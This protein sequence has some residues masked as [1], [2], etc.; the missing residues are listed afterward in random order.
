MFKKLLL[1]LMPLLGVFLVL[2]LLLSLLIGAV[3][4][5]FSSTRVLAGA[6]AE[7][8]ADAAMYE[9]YESL[10]GA[11]NVLDTWVVNR[12]PV[13]PDDGDAGEASPENP[14]YPGQGVERLGALV[15]PY[16]NDQKLRLL[17]GQSHAAALYFAYTNGL[18]EISPRLQEATI[19]D[20]HPYYYYK[21]SQVI[22]V[23]CDQYGCE[24]Y[25]YNQYLLVEAYTI[26]GH[27]QYHYQWVTID[28]P[29]GSITK[30]E[31]RDS[32]QIL[33]NNWQRLEDWIRVEYRVNEEANDLELARTAVWEAGLAFNQ[34]REWLD[35]LIINKRNDLYL[36]RF[37]I[38]PELIPLFEEAA[39]VYGVPWWF[40]AAVAYVESSFNPRAENPATGC[41]G[42]MQFTP[43]NWVRYASLLGFDPVLDRDNPRAQIMCGAYMLRALGLQDVDWE[44]PDWREQTL[45]VLAFYGGFRGAGA[46]SNCRSLYAGKIWRLAEEFNTTVSVWPTPG[47]T[48]ISA[49]FGENRG[50]HQHGGIDIAA[51]AGALVTSASTGV[52]RYAGW[53]NPNDHGAGFGL[54]VMVQDQNNAYF[55]GHLNQID[56]RVGQEVRVGTRLGLVGNTGQSTGPHLH[57]EIRVGGGSGYAIDPLPTLLYY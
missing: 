30:E 45:E 40:L 16:G 44:A 29:G 8:G 25:I 9:R 54:Y 38:P 52:V 31:I 14:F 24:T 27:F 2:F 18:T 6:K 48:K 23:S 3:Y 20:L 37:S 11:Y 12:D 26:Q 55:Y 17:W 56:V 10:G 15:D 13:R 5:A 22:V 57:F 51:A 53:Q 28:L 41:Y 19:A 47:Y 39:L 21:K 34:Q 1:P 46:L 49:N 4:S 35:W 7:A 50:D 33:A 43:A 32:Q 42:L 36:S